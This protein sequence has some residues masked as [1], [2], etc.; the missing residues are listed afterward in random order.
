MPQCLCYHTVMSDGTSDMKTVNGRYLRL[1][2][3]LAHGLRECGDTFFEIFCCALDRQ[4]ETM[5]EYHI[6][7]MKGVHTMN[8]NIKKLNELAEADEAL[9]RKLKDVLCNGES[10]AD[11]GNDHKCYCMA[12][13][14]GD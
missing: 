13:G 8:A 12:G 14:G 7:I 6:A 1:K 4:G 9:R 10:K 3:I 2:E 5:D 11:F